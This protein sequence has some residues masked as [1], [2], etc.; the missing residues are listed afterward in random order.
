MTGRGRTRRSLRRGSRP[1]EVAGEASKGYGRWIEGPLELG[2]LGGAKRMG[3][4][5]WTIDAFRCTRCSHLELF[6]RPSG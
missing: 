2:M 1:G 3:R 4:Q 5:R 6:V